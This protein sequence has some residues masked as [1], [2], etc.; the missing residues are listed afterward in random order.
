MTDAGLLMNR[1]EAL[2]R[3]RQ[4]LDARPPGTLQPTSAP[5]EVLLAMRGFMF[6]EEDEI[7]LARLG[8]G[9][10]VGGPHQIGVSTR[11]NVHGTALGG[12]LICFVQ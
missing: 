8:P 9:L 7:R 4:L 6:V 10:M 2:I 11:Q 12:G 3:R 5:R 1:L